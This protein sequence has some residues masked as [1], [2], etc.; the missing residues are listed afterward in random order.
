MSHYSNQTFLLSIVKKQ[1]K[2][3]ELNF[4]ALFQLLGFFLC[5]K[6]WFQLSVT[7]ADF[8]SS[9]YVPQALNMQ[10]NPILPLMF[11]ITCTIFFPGIPISMHPPCLHPSNL[12]APQLT[13][14]ELWDLSLVVS[15]HSDHTVCRGT[16][17]ETHMKDHSD[18]QLIGWLGWGA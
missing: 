2:K 11:L 6:L 4:I 3:K 5:K 14:L 12:S 16:E 17:R 9:F 13:W 10:M 15:A 8:E 18:L 7:K 1:N